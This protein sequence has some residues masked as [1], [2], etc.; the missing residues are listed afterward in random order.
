MNVSPINL[1]TCIEAGISMGA[2][3]PLHLVSRGPRRKPP[4]MFLDQQVWYY[5]DDV[6]L[7]GVIHKIA[8]P[9]RRRVLNYELQKKVNF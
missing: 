3:I 2:N 5:S 4:F 6:D 8:Y 1:N 7:L 9:Y